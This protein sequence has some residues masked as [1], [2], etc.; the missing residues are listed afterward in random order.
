MVAPAL[1]G[2]T[3]AP[4]SHTIVFQFNGYSYYP[5]LFIAGL[6]ALILFGIRPTVWRRLARRTR[7]VVLRRDPEEL[8]DA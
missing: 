4:G 6:L 5:M 2:V 8:A 1:V 3:V 7:R